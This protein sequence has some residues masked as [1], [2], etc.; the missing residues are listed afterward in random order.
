MN[1]LKCI[2]VVELREYKGFY[3]SNSFIKRKKPETLMNLA[4]I[5]LSAFAWLQCSSRSPW[6]CLKISLRTYYDNF[7]N[8]L[9]LSYGNCMIILRSPC[10]HIILILWSFYQHFMIILQS[11][12][13]HIMTILWSPYDHLMNIIWSSYD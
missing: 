5:S 3:K 11:S 6:T 1:D 12:Y 8:I 4:Q 2:F 7:I 9:W 10:E 13:D